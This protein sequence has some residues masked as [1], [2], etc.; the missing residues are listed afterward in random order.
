M[1]NEMNEKQR[2]LPQVFRAED[3]KCVRSEAQ[4]HSHYYPRLEYLQSFADTAN[5]ILLERS[6]RVQRNFKCDA[7]WESAEFGHV[8]NPTHKALLIAIE[9]I[10]PPKPDTAEG[11]L[12]LWLSKSSW[13]SAEMND[14]NRRASVLVDLKEKTAMPPK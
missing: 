11:L 13:T 2:S 10:V 9:P 14:F 12:R 4:P 1:N 8:F 7:G 3:F 5:R 6:E